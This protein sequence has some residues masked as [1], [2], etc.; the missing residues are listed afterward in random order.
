MS[1]GSEGRIDAQ[2]AEDAPAIPSDRDACAHLARI[3]L[4]LEDLDFEV[5]LSQRDGRH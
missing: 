1:Q 4:L 5:P 2:G 3:R